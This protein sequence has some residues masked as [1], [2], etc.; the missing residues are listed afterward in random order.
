MKRIATGLILAILFILLILY[1]SII[2]FTAVVASIAGA[3]FT[4]YSRMAENRGVKLFYA[5]GVVSAIVI[6]TLFLTSV[7]T[8]YIAFSLILILMLI[9][10]VSAAGKEG[11]AVER[12]GF[13]MFGVLYIGLCLSAPIL[14]R[15]M[16]DGEKLVLLAC[17]GIWG[18]DIGAYYIGKSFGKRKLAPAVSPGKTVEGMIGGLFVAF[19]SCFVF[20]G[21]FFKEASALMIVAAAIS[22]GIFGMFGDLSESM[23]KRYFGVKDSGSILPGHG[24]ILDRIDALMLAFPAFYIFMVLMESFA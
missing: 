14:V 23:I 9:S 7:E 20:A 17:F 15:L 1:G 11:D 24:G 2:F 6:P 22:G 18:A 3:A 19:A 10:A 12:L 21:L 8:V 5:L 4:E 13:T 16:P